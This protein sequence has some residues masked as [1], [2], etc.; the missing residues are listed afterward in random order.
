MPQGQ[1][2]KEKEKRTLAREMLIPNT[3]RSEDSLHSSG[4]DEQIYLDDDDES[5]HETVRLQRVAQE[6]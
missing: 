3:A 5:S 6:Q 1:E 4:E 2:D